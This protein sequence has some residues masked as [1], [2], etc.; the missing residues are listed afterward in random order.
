MIPSP[1]KTDK[2]NYDEALIEARKMDASEIRVA[3]NQRL[4]F[5]GWAVRAYED[6]LAEKERGL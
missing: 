2:E 4:A 1:Y 6:A 3:L 5:H